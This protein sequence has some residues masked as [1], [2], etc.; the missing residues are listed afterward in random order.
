MNSCR[1]IDHVAADVDWRPYHCAA[2]IASSAE[3]NCCGAIA[4]GEC[5]S[6]SPLPCRSPFGP[7]LSKDQGRTEALCQ[8]ETH[9]AQQSA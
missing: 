3:V 5:G 6:F 7:I 2:L 9:A 1:L 8:E 4:H